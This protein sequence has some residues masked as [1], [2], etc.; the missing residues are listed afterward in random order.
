MDVEFE[1][2]HD[3]NESGD[4]FVGWMLVN[5]TGSA[6]LLESSPG[7][8]HDPICQ[9]ERLLLI[10]GNKNGGHIQF[11]MQSHQPFTQFLSNFR[12]HRSERLI[13]Q[14]HG[15]FWSQSASDSDTLP[16]P[17]RELVWVTPFQVLQTKKR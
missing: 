6:Y 16:L 14:K 8:D 12:V 17:A 7:K 11:L 1:D 2:V 10:V 4:E 5:F 15:R 13:Q 3:A 9:F